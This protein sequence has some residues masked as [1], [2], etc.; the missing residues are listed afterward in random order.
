MFAEA[1]NITFKVVINHEQQYS[2][3]PDRREN[4]PGWQDAGCSGSRQQCLDFIAAKWTD[5]RPA[6]L[7]NAQAMFDAKAAE[8]ISV[9]INHE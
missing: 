2:I 9:S 8:K 7:R 6:S 4:A 3:W 1:E 5:M